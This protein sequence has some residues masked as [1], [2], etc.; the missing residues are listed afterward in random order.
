MDKKNT[1]TQDHINELLAK[2][3]FRFGTVFDKCSVLHCQLPNG[4]I[5]SAESSCVDP[6]NYDPAMGKALCEK[7]IV[8]KLW[9][10]EGYRLQ[11]ELKTA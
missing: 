3:E 9:E 5:I 4:F 11:C 1:I 7:K 2:S 8:D 10:L 6:E